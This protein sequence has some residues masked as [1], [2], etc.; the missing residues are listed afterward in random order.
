MVNKVILDSHCHC[1]LTLKFEII[2]KEWDK[3]GINGGVIFSPVEEIYDRYN[4]EFYDSEYYKKSREKVHEYL[5][6]L[7]IQ[8]KNLFIFYFVWNDFKIP[9]FP[10]QGIKWH[11]HSNE[12][13]YDYYS[14][15]SEIFIDFVCKNKLP[16]LIEE[17]FH[18]TLNFINRIS[19]RTNIIIPHLGFLNGGY[20]RLKSEGIFKEKNIYAD[21]ALA[22]VWE[23]ED[24]VMNFGIE[25]L[26]FGSDFPFGS[27]YS[28]LNKIK[29]LFS[30]KSFEK[31]TSENIL[32]L[33]QTIDYKS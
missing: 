24:F 14:E 22:D 20:E 18:N 19:G 30:G 12:T 1:G 10:F 31:L 28:E 4:F 29:K 17:E 23:I 26:F 13:E 27:P 16:V 15:K 33:F 11:R 21:T 2:K 5:K 6:N 32:S 9:D 8:H 25:K 7:K 3:A